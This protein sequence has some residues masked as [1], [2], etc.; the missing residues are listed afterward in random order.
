[1]LINYKSWSK[2]KIE[3]INGFGCRVDF[4]LF[5]LDNLN[6]QSIGSYAG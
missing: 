5:A 4:S 1:M 6:N 3:I 2:M